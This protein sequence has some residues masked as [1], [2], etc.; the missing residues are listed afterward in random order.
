M[1]GPSGRV[2][3]MPRVLSTACRDARGALPTCSFCGKDVFTVQ[4]LVSSGAAR[5]CGECVLAFAE[6]LTLS[7]RSER[8]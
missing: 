2:W 1:T 7:I 8:H 3:R 6:L 4:C 5:I